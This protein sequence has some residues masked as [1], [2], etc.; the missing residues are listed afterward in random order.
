[1]INKLS[2]ILKHDQHSFVDNKQHWNKIERKLGTKLPYDYKAFINEFGTGSI[3]EFIW[4]LTPFD[5]DEY[6]NF[7]KKGE[8][9]KEAYKSSKLS[10]P[11]YF[12]HNIFPEK[13]GLIPWGYT[14]NGDELY[15]L[16]SYDEHQWKVIVYTSRTSDYYQYEMGMVEFIFSIISKKL[17]CPAF[18]DNFLDETSQ[19]IGC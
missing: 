19:F 3:D 14:E 13:S 7:F 12:K 4:I 1:M 5:D 18:P 16:T 8:L 11:D 9:I 2:E 15:W 10:S 6:V 17:V